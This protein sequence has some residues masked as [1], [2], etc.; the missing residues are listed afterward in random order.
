MWDIPTVLKNMFLVHN[1]TRA[2]TVDLVNW[3]LAVEVKFYIIA[4]IL[5]SPLSS[6]KVMPLAIYSAV[7]F[8]A[9]KIYPTAMGTDLMFVSFM[10]IGVLF[11]FLFNGLI[12][13]A[14]FYSVMIFILVLFFS[15]WAATPWPDTLLSIGPSYIYGLAIFGLAYVMREKFKKNIVFDYLADISYPLYVMHSLVGY[16][17]M[18]VLFE[19]GFKLRV[20]FPLTALVVLSVVVVVHILVEL[21]TI[22]LGRKL[23]KRNKIHMLPNAQSSAT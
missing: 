1:L 5:M 17:V 9:N 15:G 7:V 22:A 13:V 4:A 2:P 3:T 21:P 16:S 11:N 14:K 19:H 20:V 18:R 23:N 6:G 12:G 10:M 8:V